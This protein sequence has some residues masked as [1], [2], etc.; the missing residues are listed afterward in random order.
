M[1]NL[2]AADSG[3]LLDIGEYLNSTVTKNSFGYSPGCNNRGCIAAA[4]KAC[5]NG[6]ISQT[7]F[8]K[9][10]IR[11]VPRSWCAGGI[12]ILLNVNQVSIKIQDKNGKGCPI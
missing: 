8:D 4:E 5:A 7:I 1:T 9:G 12:L 3:H 10:G 11:C 6:I 2:P